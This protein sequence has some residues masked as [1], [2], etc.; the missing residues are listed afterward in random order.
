VARVVVVARMGTGW[1]EG[2][3]GW[4]CGWKV[5]GVF[6]TRIELEKVLNKAKLIG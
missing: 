3:R 2:V 5:A 4:A 6:V 1:E